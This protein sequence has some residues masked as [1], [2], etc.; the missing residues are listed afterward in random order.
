MIKAVSKEDYAKWLVEA[1]KEFA[2]GGTPAIK[3]A[4]V[5]TTSAE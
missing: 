1:K 2:S 4:Q 5:K 3:F